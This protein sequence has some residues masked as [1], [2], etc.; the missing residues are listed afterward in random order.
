M[1]SSMTK[2]TI[3]IEGQGETVKKIGLFDA[4]TKRAFMQLVR[5][6]AQKTSRLA[7]RNAPV[8]KKPKSKGRPGD[9]R[10]SIRAKYFDDGL[11]ATVVPRRPKGAHRHLVE[12]GTKTRY[13]KK[14]WH[15]GKMPDKPFMKPTEEAIIPEYQKKAK[16]IV[17][18][19]ETI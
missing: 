11:S 19:D 3:E 7:K 18:R 2:I 8:S 9:L 16:R 15:R 5:E 1:R 12:Y 13:T 14:G 10:R 4:K 6:T 17:D